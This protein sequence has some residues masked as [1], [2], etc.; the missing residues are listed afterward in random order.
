MVKIRRSQRTS[1]APLCSVC[2]GRRR[3]EP[4]ILCVECAHPD[5]VRTYCAVCDIRLDLSLAEAQEIF[6]LAGL[7]F[8]RT[9]VVLL[10]P[11]GCARC[12][13]DH[14]APEIYV[15]D[16]PDDDVSVRC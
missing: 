11:D 14:S 5:R 13:D 15:I 8:K 3:Q 7:T 10:F 9:G 1:T 2:D 12:R 4:I 16:E 6:G